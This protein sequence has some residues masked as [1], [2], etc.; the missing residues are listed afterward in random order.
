MLY[1]VLFILFIIALCGMISALSDEEK[2]NSDFRVFFFPFGGTFEYQISTGNGVLRGVEPAYKGDWAPL[3][4]GYSR[5]FEFFPRTLNIKE[6][7]DEVKFYLDPETG[8]AKEVER[9]YYW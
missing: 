4:G 5:R 7:W 9:D 8:Q 2:E 3:N 6:G 1:M